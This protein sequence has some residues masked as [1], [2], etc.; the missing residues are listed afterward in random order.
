M[1]PSCCPANSVGTKRLKK[2]AVTGAKVKSSTLTGRQINESKLGKV[3]S[4]GSAD[5][6]TNA[7]TAGSAPVSRLDH[8]SAAVAVP[9][10]LLAATRGTANCPTRAER[11]GRRRQDVRPEQRV[12]LGHKYC[13][14]DRLGSDR[15][16][17]LGSEHDRPRDLRAGCVDYAMTSNSGH[18]SGVC[19]PPVERVGSSVEPRQR[20]QPASVG[21]DEIPPR[22]R[23]AAGGVREDDAP[24]GQPRVG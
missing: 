17:G 1:R 20:A 13:R 7:T 16:L 21:P 4:A 24:V 10:G 6:A 2:G 8:Q 3:P 9:A 19:C 22:K 18:F 23:S 11:Y 5:S 12:H 15:I 14:E